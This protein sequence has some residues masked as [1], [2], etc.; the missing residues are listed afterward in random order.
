MG[1]SHAVS[2]N[3]ALD[4]CKLTGAVLFC[5]GG[6]YIAIGLLLSAFAKNYTK[7]E[8]Y[9]Q[10]RFKERLA[11]TVGKAG[12]HPIK[13]KFKTSCRVYKCKTS[14]DFLCD[15]YTNNESTN[16]RGGQGA[17]HTFQSAEHSTGEH[18]VRVLIE[19]HMMAS[20]NIQLRTP[21]RADCI[22]VH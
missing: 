22:S 4:V 13:K 3:H 20:S 6:T 18:K 7:K 11:A 8:Q 17:C 9:L 10:Q 16:P 5:V 19:T 21:E 2:F 14:S 15:R 1:N 12:L